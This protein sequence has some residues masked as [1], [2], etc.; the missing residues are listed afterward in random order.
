MASLCS[1]FIPE[2]PEVLATY[3]TAPQSTLQ[4][5]PSCSD[6]RTCHDCMPSS[7]QLRSAP[8]AFGPL[9]VSRE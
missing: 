3:A 7:C 5:A 8:K 2:V 1:V 4:G 9:S 6:T